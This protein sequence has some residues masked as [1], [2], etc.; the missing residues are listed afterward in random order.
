M[1][2]IFAIQQQFE[3][4]GADSAIMSMKDL[5]AA[6]QSPAAKLI[7]YANS[8]G[9]KIAGTGSEIKARFVANR[10]IPVPPE[11]LTQ[12]NLMFSNSP[13]EPV[14]IF[15]HKM[16][17]VDMANASRPEITRAVIKITTR[18]NEKPET[19]FEQSVML[20]CEHGIFDLYT[21][22]EVDPHGAI[23]VANSWWTA[24]RGCVV[25]RCGGVCVGALTACSGTWAGYLACVAAAC[26]GCWLTCAACA[27]CDCGW[28]CR[29]L[30]G[31]CNQ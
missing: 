2:K 4:G 22:K 24:A 10:A 8:E 5:Q 30:I 16:S 25:G 7:A 29:P 11:V 23:C 18:L 19:E 1:E 13:P 21:E 14:K 28:F 9:Y 20:E 31:C 15:E 17:V 26:G 27:T 6:P 12:P 3:F